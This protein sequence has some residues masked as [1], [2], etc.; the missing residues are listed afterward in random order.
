MNPDNPGLQGVRVLLGVTG[1]IAA[2]KAAEWVRA[3]VKEE[4][5]VTVMM[6]KSASQFVSSLTFA[7]LSGNRVYHDMFETD[8]DGVMAHITLSRDHDV[9]LLAPATAQTIARLGHG[10]A[11]DLIS[12]VCLASNKP[13]VVCP[14]MNTNMYMHRAT[15]MNIGQL[16]TYGY[17]IVDPDSGE[18]ACGEVGDGRLPDWDIARE[19]LLRVLSPQDL[20]GQK[21]LITAGPTREAID[22]V[23]YVT[24]RSS[25]KMGYAL[26]RAA[27][28]R[29]AQV[30]LISGP[31]SLPAPAGVHRV[32]VQSAAD[33]EREVMAHLPA[34][35]A[36][37]KSAAVA[38][39]RPKDVKEHKIKKT[40]GPLSLEFTENNDILALVGHK[41]RSHQVIVGFAAES[42]HHVQEGQRKL[43]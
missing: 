9:V 22:P 31:V 29:G 2:Y 5:V 1:S 13:V 37:I 28:R 4:A 33:M 26:A 39:Y 11:D 43:H 19:A 14:A 40:E 18:L 38:D 21:L 15:Q 20:E 35:S 6:T 25:G 10:V 16:K 36:V 42:K 8:P 3:L 34:A 27:R 17:H 7:A 41:R 12:T 23:R 30:T 24:N 32:M